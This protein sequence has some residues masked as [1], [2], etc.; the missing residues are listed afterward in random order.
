MDKA[1]ILKKL[2]AHK[3]DIESFGVR[4]IGLFGSYASNDANA[5]SDIDIYV[6]FEESKASYDNLLNLYDYLEA[7]F[8]E[9]QVD[10]ITEG[11]VSPYLEPE[12]LENTVYA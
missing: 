1:T 12:I 5:D 7:L 8:P 9:K 10:I 3:N 2:R 4:Q 11:G 6:I